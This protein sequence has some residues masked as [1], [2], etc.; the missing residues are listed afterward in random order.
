MDTEHFASFQKE[1]PVHREVLKKCIRSLQEIADRIDIT[2][3]DCTIAN[4]TASSAGAT[5]GILRVLGLTLAPF[6]AGVSL[7]LTATGI[8]LGAA[9]AAAGISASVSEYII[10]S[11]GLRKLQALMNECKESLRL[12]MHPDEFDFSPESTPN[13]A[14]LVKKAV[15][16]Y[17][18]PEKFKANV[19]ALKVARANPELAALA[20]QATAAGIGTRAAMTGVEEAESAFRGTALAMTKGAR[21]LSAAS[22]GFFFL[23]DAYSLIQGVIHLTEGAK[24]DVAAKIRDKASKL[25][26]ALQELNKLYEE[27]N[28]ED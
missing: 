15:S 16:I 26:E 5:S 9:A 28:K 4:I 17:S 27:L 10:D 14:K 22:A 13:P 20:Q 7:I 3:K 11:E 6:S 19:K 24:A 23:Y 25:E 12:V 8:G 1:F 18:A 21:M 2:H